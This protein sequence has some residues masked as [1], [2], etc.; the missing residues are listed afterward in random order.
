MSSMGGHNPVD[1]EGDLAAERESMP[2]IWP[3]RA[4]GL[5][6]AV[7]IAA[8]L[9]LAVASRSVPEP[10]AEIVKAPDLLLDLNSVPPR[11][12][13]TLPHV[14]QS[15]VRQIV[16]ARE[17]RPITS[18]DDAG[19]RVRGLGPSTL[20]QIAPYLRFEP[21]VQENLADS[22]TAFADPPAVKS[23]STGR[24]AK[25]TRSRKPKSA[26]LQPRLVSRLAEPGPL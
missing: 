16:A 8:A 12:L 22:V 7:A 15:L 19:S 1:H 4:R 17:L 20:A 26:P 3:A 11:V 9:G 13:E 10:G 25:T 6:A 18:L 14:G 24:K 21:S 5:L 23:R 2:W